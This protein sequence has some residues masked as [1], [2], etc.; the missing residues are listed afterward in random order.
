MSDDSVLSEQLCL[1][2]PSPGPASHPRRELASGLPISCKWVALR[3]VTSPCPRWRGR[4]LAWRQDEDAADHLLQFH[5]ELVP[6]PGPDETVEFTSGLR[7]RI[8]EDVDASR[9]AVQ[10]ISDEEDTIL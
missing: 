10:H 4:G 2:G 1:G 6:Q 9:R 8:R 3:D 7:E 5:V